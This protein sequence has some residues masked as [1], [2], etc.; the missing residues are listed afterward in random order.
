MIMIMMMKMEA[1]RKMMSKSSRCLLLLYCSLFV[2]FSFILGS[3]YVF[4][5]IPNLPLLRLCTI[6]QIVK[7]SMKLTTASI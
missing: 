1:T 3:V 6:K 2:N 5:Y 7:L 4:K